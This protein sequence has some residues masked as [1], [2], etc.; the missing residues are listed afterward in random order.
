MSITRAARPKD[1]FYV[2]RNE[3]SGDRKLSWAARGM[4]IYLLSKPDDWVISIQN[5]VNETADSE[6]PMGRDAVYKVMGQLIEA[7]Y[8]SR[9]QSR[10]SG[11]MMAVEYVAHESPEP[12]TDLPDTASPHTASPD[13]V[14]PTLL[15]TETKLTTESGKKAAKQT[16]EPPPKTG[17]FQDAIN[18]QSRQGRARLNRPKAWAAWQRLSKVHGEQKLLAAYK[19]YLTTDKD[20]QRDNGDWQAGL[21]VWLNQKADIWLDQHTKATTAPTLQVIRNMVIGAIYAPTSGFDEYKA[22]MT[23]QEA[24]DLVAAAEADG[25][26]VPRP[27]VTEHVDF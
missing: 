27:K 5:L 26:L 10:K 20:A 17:P 1:N 15:N 25:R 16:N 6:S 14:K 21:Q 7:G 11:K 3:I 19:R 13:T 9:V 4:L 18:A 23:F 8:V 2:L 22:G 12:L 24:K